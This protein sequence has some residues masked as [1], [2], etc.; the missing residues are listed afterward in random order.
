[1]FS[2][3]L[4]KFSDCSMERMPLRYCKGDTTTEHTKPEIQDY[5]PLCLSKVLSGGIKTWH[6]NLEI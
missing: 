4:K 1:M 5:H 2:A 3:V 6:I